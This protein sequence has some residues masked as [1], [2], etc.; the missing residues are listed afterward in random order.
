MRWAEI[1]GALASPYGQIRDTPLV[2][3]PVGLLWAPRGRLLRALTFT[4][5]QGKMAHIEVIADHARLH[6]LHL[7][8][9]KE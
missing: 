8:V 6:K 9:L 2:N 4:L 5:A 1:H 3:G 7:A